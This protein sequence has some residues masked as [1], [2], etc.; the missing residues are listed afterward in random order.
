MSSIALILNEWLIHDL[1]G[2]NGEKRQTESFQFIERVESKNDY[3][4]VLRG[5]Q[6]M[7]KAFQLMS[8]SQFDE[9]LRYFSKFLHGRLLRNISKCKIYNECEISTIPDGIKTLISL[10]DS[11]LVALNLTEPN[12]IIIT[13]DLKLIETLSKFTNIKLKERDEYLASYI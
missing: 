6:W 11:Y 5:S 3:L 2:E 12:S 4:V 10:E 1:R 7:N 13:T 8:D 9:K